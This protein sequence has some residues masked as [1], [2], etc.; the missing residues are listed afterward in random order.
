MTTSL[1]TSAGLEAVRGEL[2]RLRRSSRLE[3]EQYL[4]DAPSDGDGSNDD[5]QQPARVE[6]RAVIDVNA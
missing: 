3:I 6:G 4:R 1:M 5:E 2:A